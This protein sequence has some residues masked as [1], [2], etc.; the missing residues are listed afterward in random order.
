LFADV[1]GFNECFLKFPVAFVTFSVLSRRKHREVGSLQGPTSVGTDFTH[2]APYI[3]PN[4]ANNSQKHRTRTDEKGR[5][6]EAGYDFGIFPEYRTALHS[7]APDRHHIGKKKK[8]G[9]LD[10]KQS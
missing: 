4:L 3:G 5:Q 10:F 1:A 8:M 9:K 6:E 2:L 7:H